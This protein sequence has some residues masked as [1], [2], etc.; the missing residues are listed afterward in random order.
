MFSQRLPLNRDKTGESMK[1]LYVG[2]WEDRAQGLP[3]RLLVFA[4][5]DGGARCIQT[6]RLE[7]MVAKVAADAAHRLVFALVNADSRVNGGCGGA[8]LSW[9]IGPDGR[10]TPAAQR[11]SFGA[12]PIDLALTPENIVLVNHGSTTN[13]VCRTQRDGP[14]E[15]RVYWEYDEASVV[16]LARGPGGLPGAF[17]DLHKCCGSG[18]V[19]FFQESAAPHS[20]HYSAASGRFLVP[21][22]GSDRTSVFAVQ[23]GRL[24]CLAC[25]PE[26]AGFGPRNAAMTRRG[27]VYVVDEIE[28]C[29]T[30]Y[31]LPDTRAASRAATVSDETRARCDADVRSFGAPHPVAV[32]LSADEAYLYTLTRST[33]TLDVFRLDPG[34]GAPERVQELALEGSNPRAAL[35]AEGGAY[36]TAMDAGSCVFVHTDAA[37]GL[38]TAQQTLFTGVPGI[39]TLDVYEC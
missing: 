22:R 30:H 10:L 13:R 14:G 12:S 31:R 15:P 29:V 5:E 34:T 17:L 8:L 36:V 19:P 24:H 1:F 39:D 23:S 11:A 3:A 20:L 35:P 32:W 9:R 7:S 26:R 25:L 37:T 4:C 33:D 2:A 6:I 21:E 38:V 28:P 27:D 18:G 16:L